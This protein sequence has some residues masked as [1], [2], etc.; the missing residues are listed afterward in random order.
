MDEENRKISLS[1]RA[2]LEEKKA[3]EEQ[4]D[5]AELE[6]SAVVYSTDNPQSYADADT[7][8]AE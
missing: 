4:G 7:G 6:E 8:D 2:L 5:A 3:A 1:I